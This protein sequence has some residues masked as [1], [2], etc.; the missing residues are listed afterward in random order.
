VHSFAEGATASARETLR[1]TEEKRQAALDRMDRAGDM[2]GKEQRV[3]HKVSVAMAGGQSS[4]D[5]R[6]G[7]P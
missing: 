5:Q 3:M 6:L 4:S 2:Q 7:L 1:S